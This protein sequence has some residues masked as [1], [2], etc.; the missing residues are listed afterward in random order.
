MRTVNENMK[1]CYIIGAAP[2]VDPRPAPGAADIVIAA[3]GGLA[4]ARSLGL[5]PSLA[6]GDF[7]SLGERPADIPTQC[8]PVE[9]D[10]TDTALALRRAMEADCRRILLFGCTGGRPD[11]TY[12][13]YL[14]LAE[15]A[16]GGCDAWMF[17]DGYAVTCLAP[18]SLRF[19]EKLLGTVSVFALTEADGVCETGLYYT[20]SDASLSC[21]DPLGVSNKFCGCAAEISLRKGKL[22]IFA[23]L[24]DRSPEAFIAE[25]ERETW[26]V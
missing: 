9:K 4:A 13:N 17:G 20:L 8:H 15:A 6:V 24:G 5:A 3:D 18:G 22:L 25:T 2:Q 1:T 26:T 10:E 14:A 16:A 23:E 19:S 11:H 21:E 12:A 7:D